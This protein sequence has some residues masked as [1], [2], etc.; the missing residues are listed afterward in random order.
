M[1]NE[2]ELELEDEF[3]GEFEGELEVELEVARRQNMCD[4]ETYQRLTTRVERIGRML[5]GLIASI[6]PD[7]NEE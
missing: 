4:A 1:P 5:N 2:F 3:E 7:P 6:K